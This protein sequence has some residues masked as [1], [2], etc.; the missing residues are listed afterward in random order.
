MEWWW[1]QWPFVSISCCLYHTTDGLCV[2]DCVI[3]IH[4]IVLARQ[5]DC[6]TTFMLNMMIL[7]SNATDADA[8]LRFPTKSHLRQASTDQL[9]SRPIEENDRGSPSCCL[10]Q[11]LASPWTFGC[12]RRS[13]DLS[14]TRVGSFD[15]LWSTARRVRGWPHGWGGDPTGYLTGTLCVE[16]V[17]FLRQKRYTW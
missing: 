7:Y 3:S 17:H 12:R 9:A 1:C 16:L 4:F 11:V 8:F 5:Q 6:R 15:Y 10:V 14:P 2:Y 13:I